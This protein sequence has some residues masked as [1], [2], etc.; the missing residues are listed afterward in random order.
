M[1]EQDGF[2]IHVAD[3]QRV[4]ARSRPAR[5][6]AGSPS[7][8]WSNSRSARFDVPLRLSRRRGWCA[9]QEAVLVGGG[10]SAGQAV[11]FLASRTWKVFV[12]VEA[13]SLE[14]TPSR[15]L[16]DLDR[17]QAFL[18]VQ[19]CLPHRGCGA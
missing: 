7:P 13:L 1:R 2:R 12:L 16:I 3:G 8:I 9:G 19:P 5:V 11:A 14:A 6:I 4:A 15:Y 18:Y 10:N 17:L